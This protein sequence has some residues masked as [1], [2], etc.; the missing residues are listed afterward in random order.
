MTP[1]LLT[2]ALNSAAFIY[3]SIECGQ[4]GQDQKQ[5]SVRGRVQREV[6]HAV[7]QHS[8]TAGQRS[9]S[10][11]TSEFVL[12]VTSLKALTKQNADEGEAKNSAD[13]PGIRESLQIVVVC[14]LQPVVTVARVEASVNRGE[15]SEA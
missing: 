9:C 13:D 4:R 1:A 12:S 14:L 8:E 7:N 15:R 6:K 2:P 5:Q 11:T 10:H 3:T